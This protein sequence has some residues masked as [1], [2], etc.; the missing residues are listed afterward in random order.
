MKGKNKTKIYCLWTTYDLFEKGKGCKHLNYICVKEIMTFQE[1]KEKY[2]EAKF[3]GDW[4]KEKEKT[5]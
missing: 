2:P 4:T 1:A 3:C 5:K